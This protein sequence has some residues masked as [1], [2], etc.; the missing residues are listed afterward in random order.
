MVYNKTMTIIN[1]FFQFLL[2]LSVLLLVYA[3]TLTGTFSSSQKLT[4]VLNQSGF[5]DSLA[6]GLSSQLQNQVIGNAE[7]SQ[8]IKSGISAGVTPDLVRSVMQPSQIATVDWLNHSSSN[9]DIRLDLET[10]KDKILAKVEDPKAKFEVVKILPDM[11]V[12]IDTKSTQTGIATGLERFK[13]T[14]SIIKTSVPVLWAISVGSAL[15]LLLINLA[16][17][18]KKITRICYGLVFGSIVGIALA[19]IFRFIASGINLSVI[20]SKSVID[21]TLVTKIMVT[22]ISQTLMTFVVIGSIA[23]VGILLAKIIFRGRD[24]KLKKK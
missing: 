23:V 17:G 4:E 10:V 22:I 6:K 24:K 12:V 5:Y 2:G 21:A 15:V 1:K 20:D 14:Y 9:L 19:F 7:V 16:G 11:I 18:S 8:A 3:M 13:Q